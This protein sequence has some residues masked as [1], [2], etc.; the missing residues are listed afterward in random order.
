MATMKAVSDKKD[1]YLV[2]YERDPP[3]HRFILLAVIK[4]M[5]VE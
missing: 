5:R 1:I 4:K 3:C 2:C